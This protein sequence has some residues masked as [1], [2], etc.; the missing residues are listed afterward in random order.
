MI[1]VEHR[2]ITS[3]AATTKHITHVRAWRHCFSKLSL[4]S[5]RHRKVLPHFS[6]LVRA[7]FSFDA[8]QAVAPCYS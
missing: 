6:K 1:S 7:E 3:Q 4:A 8:T 2:C 5:N